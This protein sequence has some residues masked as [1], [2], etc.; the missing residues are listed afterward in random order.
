MTSRAIAFAALCF[1]GAMSTGSAQ[2][3]PPFDR[4]KGLPVVS[5]PNND[6]SGTPLPTMGPKKPGV[7]EVRPRYPSSPSSY[8]SSATRLR[9]QK[10][11]R[12]SAAAQ[13]QSGLDQAEATSLITT[14]GY[15]RVG[16]VRPDPNSIWV[17]QADAMKNGRRVRLGIDNHGHLLEISNGQPQPCT[18]PAICSKRHVAIH[19]IGR[20]EWQHRPLAC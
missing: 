13:Q 11:D 1:I 12:N 6:T 9:T 14:Q 3:T 19:G 20:R 16:E 18:T 7:Q 5:A 2:N 4:S 8:S 15:S 17:W 10:I